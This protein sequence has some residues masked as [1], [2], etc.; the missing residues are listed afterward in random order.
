MRKH[1]MPT[2]TYVWDDGDDGDDDDDDD[3]D[4]DSDWKKEQCN[5]LSI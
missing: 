5:I 1:D 2:E 3:D 4:D